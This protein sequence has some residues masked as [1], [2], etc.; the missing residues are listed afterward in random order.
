MQDQHA[1]FR[2]ANSTTSAEELTQLAKDGDPVIRGAVAANPATPEN[3]IH[4]LSKDADSDVAKI[5]DNRTPRIEGKNL[6]LRA[7]RPA[8]AA[9]IL[10][11]RLNAAKNR[12]ISPV[13]PDVQKQADY[14]RGYVERETVGIEYYFIMEDKVGNA[15]GTVR[16]Y[17]FQG[18]SFCWGSWLTVPDAPSFAAIESAL[19]VYDF[20]FDSLGFQRSHFDVRKGNE[21]VIAFH[22][23]FG[24]K[25]TGETELD[26]LFSFSKQDYQTTRAKY[27]KYAA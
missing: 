22:T 9:F 15:L 6:V 23:R 12:F 24:A 2:H 1:Q 13:S 26:L 4:A 14:L 8:D 5:A 25:V 3:V 11:L 27:R 17:D 19:L 21:K 20:A 7:A 10:S 18:D 16:L